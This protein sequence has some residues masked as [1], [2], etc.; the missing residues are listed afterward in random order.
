MVKLLLILLVPLAAVQQFCE[1]MVSRYPAATL[2]DV[3]KSCY[4]DFFGAEHMVRDTAAARRYLRYELEQMAQES[5]S[6]AMLLREPTGFRHRFVRINLQTV[7][8]G[9][10]TEDELL[11]RFLEAANGTKDDV[12]YANE[13]VDEWAEIERI[14]LDVHPEWK[15]AALQEALREAA[16][17]KTAVHHSESYRFT[18]KPHYR[19]ILNEK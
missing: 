16:A 15:D 2:Q 18:Y 10:M 6:K 9:Q 7:L 14:A 4:Q 3:Y 19:I 13:W 5:S 17:K 1:D 11:Q 8:N 12:R